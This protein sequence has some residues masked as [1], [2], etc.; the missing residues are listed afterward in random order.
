[1]KK[2]VFTLLCAAAL[3]ACTAP[4]D[5]VQE[6]LNSY[7]TV[8]IGSSFFSGI[9]DNGRQVLD[10]FR[11]TADEIDNIYWDQSFGDKAELAKLP[12]E[13]QRLYAL[14]NY[15]PWD[16]RDAQPFVEGYGERPAGA[17]FYPAD[18]T[19]EEFE[20][21]EDPAKLSPYTLIRRAEDGSLKVVWYHDAYKANIDKIANYLHAAAD[22]TIK[23]SVRNYLLKK[24]DA[25]RTD[26]YYDSDIA[27]LE[28]DDSKMDLVIGP[29]E[30]EDDRRY[31]IKASYEAFV[32]LKDLNLTASLQEFTQMIPELQKSLPC[33]DEYKSFVPGDSSNIFAYDAV[34]YAG[35]ANSGTKVIAINLPYDTR[36]QEEKGTRTALLNNV[37]RE[38]FY[39][40][41][42]PAGRLLIEKAQHQGLDERAF[43]WNI[44][45]RE[46]AHGLGVKQ[47]VNGKGSVNDA[48][49]N[50]ALAIEEMKGDILGV[51]LAVKL[52]NEGRIDQLVT[53]EDAITTFI[54]GLIRSSRFG[55]AEALGK[56]NIACYNYLKEAGAFAHNASGLYHIDYDKAEAAIASLSEK[57]L[58]IQA[59]GD[60]EA[61]REL[62]GT[63][64]NVSE[65]LAQDFAALDRAHIPTDVRFQFVW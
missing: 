60:I 50:E 22:Y 43:F 65:S 55:S 30:T 7:A 11:L 5:P 6:K 17:N 35:G 24:I 34:Y 62:L 54:A 19:D 9:S 28:M 32:L 63:Y 29:N 59:T 4:A 58:T 26:D 15:G 14:V 49:G 44:A 33:K 2:S 16:R 8:E 12:T 48:L 21:L 52:V 51:Y 40:I 18:M 41:V 10:Y 53:R 46:V 45:F 31:G 56:A 27:W 3:A 36:V 25:L 13:A 23:P 57:I 37:I 1:M 61:A 64:G 39:K 47:T 42:M 38:K 20:A